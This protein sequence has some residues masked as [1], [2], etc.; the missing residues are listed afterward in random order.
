MKQI[1]RCLSLALTGIGIGIPVAL[2]CMTLIG[3]YNAVIQEFLIWTVASALFGILSGL[4]FHNDDRL[5][6]PAATLLH[7]IGCMAITT[8]AC[9]LC[10]YTNSLGQLV[11][12]ILPVFILIYVL[13]YGVIMLS[14]KLQ[15]KKINKDLS[16]K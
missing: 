12:H 7:C 2:V 13:I 9:F 11:V 10:G 8:G 15:E 3:G 4:T 16:S 5:N 1:S 6:L 14:S